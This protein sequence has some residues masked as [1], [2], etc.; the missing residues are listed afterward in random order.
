MCH[1][2]P[3]ALPPYGASASEPPVVPEPLT[4]V[5]Y[6][7]AGAGICGRPDKSSVWSV[8][9]L[10]GHPVTANNFPRAK[11]IGNTDPTE[12]IQRKTCTHDS[13]WWG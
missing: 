6:P 9:V 7:P 8:E 5:G 11:R 10:P 12:L 13:E 1:A 3:T 4:D 2:Q